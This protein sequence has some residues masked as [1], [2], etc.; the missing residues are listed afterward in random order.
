MDQLKAR[1]QELTFDV[2]MKVLRLGTYKI[3]TADGKI[4]TNAWNI[5]QLRRFYP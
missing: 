1:Q 5:K 2:I 4:F 3:K